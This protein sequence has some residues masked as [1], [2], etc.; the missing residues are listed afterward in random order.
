MIEY[1]KGRIDELTPATATIECAGVGYLINIS[2]NTYSVLQGKEEAKIY[3]YEAIREDA[4]TLFGFAT[5]TF[6]P[7][8]HTL[9]IHASVKYFSQIDSI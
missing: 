8:V 3:V 1:L 2:L 9:S 6:P 4:W 7:S 5:K